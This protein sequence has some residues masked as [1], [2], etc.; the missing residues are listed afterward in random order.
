MKTQHIILLVAGILGILAFFFPFLRFMEARIFDI[1]LLSI[2]ISGW[3]YVEA[4]LDQ[5]D[6]VDSRRG[7]KLTTFLTDMWENSES[8]SEML[9]F[10][11]VLY[12]LM[13]PVIFLFHGLGYTM[14]ALAGASYKSGIIFLLT[15]TFIAWLAFHY[16]G[17]NYHIR[18]NFFDKADWGYWLGCISILLAAISTLFKRFD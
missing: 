14:R 3:Q 12:I 16:T 10:I 8:F 1:H 5:F 18:L 6:L 15:Y 7:R 17:K 2:K 9:S 11:V 13:G 4:L